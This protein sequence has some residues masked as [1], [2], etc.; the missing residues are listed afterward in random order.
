MTTK[1]QT[2]ITVEHQPS[3]E[4]LEALGVANWSI[5]TKEASEFPWTYDMQET[6]YILA[7]EVTVTPDHGEAVTL[8]KGDLV[9]FPA[10]MSCTWKITKDIRKHYSFS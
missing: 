8:G 6:C 10:G 9:T 4:R 3:P 5:W 1:Q 7:G 2:K